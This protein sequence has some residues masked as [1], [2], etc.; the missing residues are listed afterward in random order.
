MSRP[1]DPRVAFEIAAAQRR[2][3]LPFERQTPQQARAA[4]RAGC[5][6]TGPVPV[7]MASISDVVL[8][9][10]PCRIYR[11]TDAAALPA[12]LYVH[13][14]GWVIGDLESHDS[15]CRKLAA[16]TRSAVV[17]VDYRL[18]PE[19]PF[20]APFDDVLAA[21]TALAARARTL[22]LAPGQLGIAGDSAGAA[23]AASVS[24]A[25]RGGASALAP[26][27]QLLF[28]PATD[29]GATS[30]S[31]AEITQGVFLTA[32][33]MRWFRSHYAPDPS[34]WTDWRA[35]PLC[36]TDL[37]RLPP[38]LVITVGHDPLRDEGVAY[39][40]QLAAGR[41]EVVHIH[42]P[43]QIHGLLT[44]SRWMPASDAVWAEAAAFVRKHVS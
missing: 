9:G 19:H 37:T 16:D 7:S 39:A 15:V 35:S 14:G 24:Q 41:N 43:D 22:G 17:A 27:F 28:Y 38:A 25:C 33:T 11:P 1:I 8:G 34:T 32:A 31:Y 21:W 13:G 5:A 26:R 40:G 20:P 10:V 2:G 6:L 23:L 42:L 30:A 12:V 18:A 36:A 4:Y 29:L 3:R 44:Q